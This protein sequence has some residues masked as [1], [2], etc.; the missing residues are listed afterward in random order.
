MRVEVNPEL[1][2][3][4]AERSQIEKA[5]LEKRFPKLG[6]WQA[7]NRLPTLRQLEEFARA[8]HTPVGYLFLEE[9]PQERLPVPDF[10][11]IADR[12]MERTSP[13]LLDTLQL[14]E[15]RQ[16]W[17]R[18]FAR[19][20]GLRPLPFVGSATLDAAPFAVADEMREVLQFDLEHRRK[21]PTW[22]EALRSFIAQAEAAGVLVMVSGV[23]GSNNTRKLDPDEFRG[24]TLVDSIA[25]L[26]FVNG[27]DTKAAQMFTLAHELAHVWL[28]GSAVSNEQ[29]ARKA[30]NRTERWCNEVAVELLVPMAVFRAEYRRDAD[31]LDEADRLA[32]RFKVSTIV[33]LRRMQDAGGIGWERFRE[34]YDIQ[35]QRWSQRPAG[36]GGDFY[37]TLG[38]RVS[39]RFARALV[40][41]TLEGHST[42][43]EAFDLLGFRKM[44]TFKELGQ[45]LGLVV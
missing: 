25:P 8:T 27:S 30:A 26:V 39:K 19:S 42:Y 2:R 14:C 21:C 45:K 7:G 36:G 4:A 40:A 43:T 23:V 32:R 18:G 10:R 12:G 38:A 16:E 24:F 13:D 15:Q 3:W 11:T 17:Y 9:P 44:A 29:I 6:E 22:I 37:S 41:S 1:L 33:I 20:A 5:D 35:M 34:L 28:G 31:P